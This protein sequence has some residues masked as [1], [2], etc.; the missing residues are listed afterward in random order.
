M[1]KKLTKFG[2][3]VLTFLLFSVALVQPVHIS[4]AD[5]VGN[6]G[7]GGGGEEETTSNRVIL[8]IEEEAVNSDNPL[9]GTASV[10]LEDQS[11]GFS[12]W[13]SQLLKIILVIA[14]ILVFIHLLLGAIK[15]ITAGGDSGKVAEAQKQMTQ[16]I[17]GLI[18]LAATVAIFQIVLN[19]LGITTLRFSGGTAGTGGGG[20][21]GGGG[22]ETCIVDETGSDGGGNYCSDDGAAYMQCFGPGEGVSAYDYNHWEP[23]Y[24]ITGEELPVFDFSSC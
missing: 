15:W 3:V 1:F 7:G 4:A 5:D 17:L 13:F 18:V 16:A 21:G 8:N 19:F 9:P 20:N 6:N 22:N 23:C 2:A 12:Y 10:D 14:T 24:C 11:S